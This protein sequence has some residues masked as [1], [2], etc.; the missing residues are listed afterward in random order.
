[1]LISVLLGIQDELKHLVD[2]INFLTARHDIL[3]VK[4]MGQ[5]FE[6]LVPYGLGEVPAI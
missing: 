4:Q 5:D 1:M 2:P 3:Q 6:H